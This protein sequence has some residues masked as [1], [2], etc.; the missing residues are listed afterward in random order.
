[1]HCTAYCVGSYCL[2]LKCPIAHHREQYLKGN[3]VQLTSSLFCLDSAA[4]LMLNE[5]M[6]DSFTCL[7]ESKLVKQEVSYTATLIPMVSV[8]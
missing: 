5:R 4:L 2:L 3:T 1:M 8:L 7:V 6:N